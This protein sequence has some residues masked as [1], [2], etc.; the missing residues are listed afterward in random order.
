LG[1]GEAAAGYS[2]PDPSPASSGP[3]SLA[4]LRVTVR[5]AIYLAAADNFA[6]EIRLLVR[7]PGDRSRAGAAVIR[8][9][10]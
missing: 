9:D 4:T 6:R 10:L 5:Q 8:G 3:T 7:P 1:L 2:D